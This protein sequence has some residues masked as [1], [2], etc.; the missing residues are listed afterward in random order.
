MEKK[1]RLLKDLPGTKRG[2]IFTALDVHDK[3]SKYWDLPLYAPKSAGLPIFLE[4]TIIASSWF[5][6][7]DERRAY[8][9]PYDL[10]S[11]SYVDHATG[12]LNNDCTKC[13][14]YGR[15]VRP[16][17]ATPILGRIMDYIRK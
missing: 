5:E 12:M 17:G 7:L 14:R 3:P 16:T 13:E 10:D 9:C 8:E 4:A 1:Y 15:G 2:V 11:C 6:E